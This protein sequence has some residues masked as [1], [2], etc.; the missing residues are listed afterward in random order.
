MISS[1]RRIEL[2]RVRAVCPVVDRLLP[3]YDRA[4]ALGALQ[5]GPKKAEQTTKDNC[6]AYARLAHPFEAPNS[7][8]GQLGMCVRSHL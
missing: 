7:G 8:D 5:C 4:V 3:T 6:A 2:N 1:E